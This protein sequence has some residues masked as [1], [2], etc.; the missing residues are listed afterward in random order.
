M[1]LIETKTLSDI[2]FSILCLKLFHLEVSFKKSFI[3]LKT[4]RTNV[5]IT[6]ALFRD[7]TVER[8]SQF[9][10]NLDPVS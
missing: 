1:D 8:D 10:I 9:T 5:T 3:S 6:S 7:H 4:F 2:S